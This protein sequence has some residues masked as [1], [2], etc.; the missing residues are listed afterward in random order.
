MG[1]NGGDVDDEISVEEQTQPVRIADVPGIPR[2]M[3]ASKS[4]SSAARVRAEGP[5]SVGSVLWRDGGGRLSCTLVAK[6]GYELSPGMCAPMA[7]PPAI[8]IGDGHWDDDPQKSV[9]VPADLSPF[10][11]APE[12]VVVGSAFAAA[13]R[14]APSATARIVV[15]SVDKTVVAWAPRVFR[16]DGTIEEAPRQV[17]FSLRWEH[18]AGGPDSDNPAGIDPGRADLRGRRAIPELLPPAFELGRPGDFVPTVGMGP[19][20]ASSRQ[21]FGYL[22]GDDRAWI[23]EMRDRPLPPGFPARFFQAAPMDQWLDRP[24]QPNE[25]L[26]LEGLHD[27]VPRLV[28]SLAGIEPWAVLVGSSAEPIRLVADLLVIDSDHALATL[29][30]RAAVSVEEG[31]AIEATIL[32]APMG[33]G[34]PAE[35]VQRARGASRPVVKLAAP[36]SPSRAAPAAHDEAWGETTHVETVTGPAL[37]APSLPFAKDPRPAHQD[38][39]P[40]SPPAPAPPPPRASHAESALPFGAHASPTATVAAVP[41]ASIPDGGMPFTAPGRVAHA[42]SALPFRGGAS[43]PPAAPA[44]TFGPPPVTAPAPPVTFGP[45]PAPI[46]YAPPSPAAASFG[47]QALTIGQ[48]ASAQSAAPPAPTTI[49]QQAAAQPSTI[50][51]PSAAIHV[52]SL[53]AGTTPASAAQASPMS[54][55]AVTP[56]RSVGSLRAEAQGAIGAIVDK[57]APAMVTGA[58]AGSVKASSDAAAAA[59]KA[60]EKAAEKATSPRAATTTEGP[61]RLAIV[62]LIA[63]DPKVAAR[64]RVLRRFAPALTAPAKA[65]LQSVDEPRRELPDRDRD[66]ADI[67]RVLCYGRPDG[68]SHVR[69]ALADSLEEGNDLDAPLV[70]VAGDLRP[71]FDEVEALKAAVSVG[72]SIAGND[73]RMLAAVALGQE[74]TA[75]SVG[76]RP[77]AAIGLARQ[78]ASAAMSLSLPADYVPTQVERV[79]LEGRKYKRRALRGGQKI[80]ADLALSPGGDVLPAYLEDAVAAALPLLP[81]CSVIALCEVRLR[82]DAAESQNEALF[83][84]AIGRVLHAREA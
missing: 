29:T 18:A 55:P 39:L 82:E 7:E 84:V 57:A 64:L 8:Q 34:P 67:L 62:H 22:G 50:E 61:V 80:R 24:L 70:L 51:R 81:S 83:P 14:A 37:P 63:F 72:Q 9:H 65:K 76:P 21:R 12:V 41:R 26:L 59:D 77:D 6:V 33:S 71:T 20:A 75:S 2:A 52:P 32:E 15:G 13:D 1:D 40:F 10:K 79:L 68:I 74:A 43:Q 49:G 47:Q 30:F 28:T 46:A 17:R 31:R 69:D 16:S 56:A 60:K 73:K 23:A 25:R 54:A 58:A 53:L 45:P 27:S 44:V 42:E 36:S 48:Q 19:I 35:V 3:K 11:A 38:A 5:F 66:R 78:I 4:S